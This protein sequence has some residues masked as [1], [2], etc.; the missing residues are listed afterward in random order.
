M[1]TILL[2]EADPTFRALIHAQLVEADHK[3]FMP[4]TVED[5]LSDLALLRPDLLILDS[6]GLPL[7]YIQQISDG[8][9]DTPLLLCTGAFDHERLDLARLKPV[10]VLTRPFSIGA[11]VQAIETSISA[12][13]QYP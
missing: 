1:G 13:S 8:R 4:D 2:V 6:V 7:D 5:A 11:L 3:V 10:H 9:R 12:K